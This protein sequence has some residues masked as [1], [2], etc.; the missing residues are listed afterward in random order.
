MNILNIVYV[1]IIGVLLYCFL[2]S[3]WN[4]LWN[5]KTEIQIQE[6]LE[7]GDDGNGGGNCESDMKTLVY[8]NAGTIQNIQESINTMMKQLN[9]IILNDDRQQTD[10]QNL[11]SLEE[12]VEKVSD[13]ANEL[14]NENKNRLL[15]L[16]KESK[17]KADD[18]TKKVQSMPS[19]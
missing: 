6:G 11:K 19:P 5:R 7:N 3:A 14:A 18:I 15:E 1:F 16:A 13:Q 8:K 4:S 10:I 12:K 17:A 2:Y 9:T